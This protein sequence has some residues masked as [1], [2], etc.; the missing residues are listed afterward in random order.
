MVLLNLRKLNEID[1][2]FSLN[3]LLPKSYK[4]AQN[5][6]RIS[7]VLAYCLNLI[8]PGVL[9][10]IFIVYTLS[11]HVHAY[12]GIIIVVCILTLYAF[13]CFFVLQYSNHIKEKYLIQPHIKVEDQ[14]RPPLGKYKLEY[15]TECL[16]FKVNRSY[17]FKKMG[18]CIYKFDHYCK[19]LGIAI[20]F[21]NYKVFLLYTLAHTLNCIIIFVVS[22][23]RLVNVDRFFGISIFYLVLTAGFMLALVSLLALHIRFILCNETTFEYLNYRWL[24]K[25]DKKNSIVYNPVL[26]SAD[27]NDLIYIDISDC[28]RIFDRNSFHA[29]I[30]DAIG[31]I[32]LWN[33][34]L[35]TLNTFDSLNL[36]ISK[37]IEEKYSKPTKNIQ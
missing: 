10:P 31:T 16:S 33:F 24:K 11:D 15:C 5:R 1:R 20:N 14:N 28:H 6:L 37:K 8:I 30:V 4:T 18:V 2:F 9:I 7:K 23:Y 21:S 26:I 3:R 27:Q 19:W 17:H 32:K 34:F 25:N 12:L 22:L 35:P 29:N 36:D 13:A